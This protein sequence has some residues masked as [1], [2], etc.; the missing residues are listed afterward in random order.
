MLGQRY[1]TK[2]IW[3]AKPGKEI[4]GGGEGGRRGGS[5]PGKAI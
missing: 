4:C 3:A 1:P 2:Y 5:K